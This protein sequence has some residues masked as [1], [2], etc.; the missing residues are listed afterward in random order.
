M[1]TF[2][3]TNTC[4]IRKHVMGFQPVP[5]YR[6][7]HA[8]PPHRLYLPTDV[9]VQLMYNDYMLDACRGEVQPCTRERYRQTVRRMNIANTRLSGDECSKCFAHVQHEVEAHGVVITEPAHHTAE[10]CASCE[11]HCTPADGD[12]G[13][14]AIQRGCRTRVAR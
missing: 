4:Y 6:Y 9:T 3:T 8:P 13:Q 2:Q 1:V 14:T 5:H 7:Q 12:G 11:S 10:G